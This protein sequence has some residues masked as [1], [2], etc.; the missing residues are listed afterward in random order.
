MDATGEKG[1]LMRP[2][3]RRVTI[4][5]VAA[6]LGVTKGTVSRAMNGYRDISPSTRR[7]VERKAKE[8]GYRP[9]SH[10]Q[11]IRTGR[12]RALGLVL[13]INEHDAQRPFLTDF[14][15]GVSMAASA[16]NWTL[17]VATAGSDRETLATISR[18]IEEHKADGFIL[19]RTLLIDTRVAL[20]R[21][22]GV[23]FIMYGRTGDATGCAWYDVLGENAMKEAV[24]RLS[25]QGH[26]R[27]GF[28]NGGRGYSYSKLR[29]EG[30]LDGLKAAGLRRD[31]AL[32]VEGA[33][34]TDQGQRAAQQL[35]QGAEP[36]TAVIYAVDMA[37]LG[38]YRAAA[39]AGLRVGRDLSVI[40]YDGIP[41]G[42]HA[43][44][45]LTSFA[46]NS[47]QAG[48]SLARLLIR[49]IRGAAPEQLRETDAARLVV[50]GSDGPP[51]LSSAEIYAHMR[52]RTLS[53]NQT[54]EED[55]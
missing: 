49:R 50:R 10:A 13:Q 39:A 37:A 15:A 33:V 48:A 14:L 6:A 51:V 40:G 12:V 34:T 21:G 54:V 53:T 22:A 31:E 9:L 23:P 16:E 52:A 38:L 2:A 24:L 41:E 3:S 30:Y 36:P 42:A 27:I 5:D 18:L 25:G 1:R 35:L 4:A 11:A 32:V 44:P 7:R 19:P 17:T 46:V 29:L 45:Q 20:L 55:Q 43:T 8:M 26:R 28:V 47:R